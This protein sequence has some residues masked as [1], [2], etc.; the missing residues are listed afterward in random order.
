MIH[1]PFIFSGILAECERFWLP[2]Q[3]L[4]EC[5]QVVYSQTITDKDIKILKEKVAIHLQSVQEINKRECTPKHHFLTH[6]PGNIEKMG[7]PINLWTMRMEVKHKV[8]TEILK[9]KKNFINPAKTMACSHQETSCNKP[10]CNVRATASLRF[11][12]FA[13]TLQ[14]LKFE[15]IL[16]QKFGVEQTIQLKN[17]KFAN[18][19]DIQYREGYFIVTDQSLCRI[20]HIISNGTEIL[21]ICQPFEIVRK[22]NVRVSVVVKRTDQ[23]ALILDLK[24]LKN[25]QVCHHIF[26]NNEYHI[27]S[28]KLFVANLLN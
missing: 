3:S 7:P 1:I 25:K 14:Y 6:Y 22:D 28:N 27:I 17:H 20:I 18:Y 8:F 11:G 16:I 10:V 4:L 13:K 24:Y 23:N 12:K 19:C 2:V 15:D 9:R 5:M 26:V 21:F